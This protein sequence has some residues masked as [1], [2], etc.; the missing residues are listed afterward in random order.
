MRVYYDRDADLARILDKKIAVVGYG[1]QGHAHA[2]NLRDSGV[3]SV[4]VALRAGSSSAKKAEAEGFEV[5]STADAAAWADMLMM[6]APD[7]V[8][9]ELYRTDIAPNIR[10]GAA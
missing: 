9:A 2:L 1:S 4:A 10:D 6:L 8:Q 5:K 7:E 3:K